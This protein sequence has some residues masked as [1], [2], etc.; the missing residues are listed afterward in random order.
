MSHD[1]RKMDSSVASLPQNDRIHRFCHSER[2]EES[3]RQQ[4]HERKNLNGQLKLK[5]RS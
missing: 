3:I 1:R 5:H 4:T 2:S